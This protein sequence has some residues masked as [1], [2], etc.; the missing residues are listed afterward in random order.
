MAWLT[1]NSVMTFGKYKGLKVSE[2]T[3]GQ[4]IQVIHNSHL[5]VYLKKL[6]T[7]VLK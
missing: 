1:N 6:L 5:N 3:D 4:T 2:I 7:D